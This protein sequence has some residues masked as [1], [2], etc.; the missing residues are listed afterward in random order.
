M[1]FSSLFLAMLLMLQRVLCLNITW[2]R[3]LDFS[4]IS[5]MPASFV[6]AFQFIRKS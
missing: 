5:S 6:S 1:L 3:S 4:F 2:G